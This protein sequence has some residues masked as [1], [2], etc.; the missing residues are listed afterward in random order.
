MNKNQKNVSKILNYTEHFFILTFVIT[1]CV[2]I[3][4]FVFLVGIPTRITS[5]TVELKVRSVTEA[6]KKYKSII[7][8]K[9]KHHDK[10]VLLN[11]TD[12]LIS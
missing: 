10:V 12:V 2:S 9:K 4:D 11:R 6:T 7:R 5:S 8:N 1:G 3:S